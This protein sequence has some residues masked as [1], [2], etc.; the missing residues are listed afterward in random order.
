LDGL[1]DGTATKAGVVGQLELP[2][3]QPAPMA[4]LRGAAV[5]EFSGTFG[6]DEGGLE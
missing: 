2:A 6:A 1:A 3:A 4:W 5:P